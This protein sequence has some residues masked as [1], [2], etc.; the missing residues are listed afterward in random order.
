MPTQIAGLPTEEHDWFMNL[1]KAALFIYLEWMTAPFMSFFG[2]LGY[3]NTQFQFTSGL[4]L[5]PPEC[6]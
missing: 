1:A 3:P 5:F 2:I 6:D 4:D